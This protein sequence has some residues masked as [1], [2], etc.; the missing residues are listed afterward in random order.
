MPPLSVQP[1]DQAFRYFQQLHF[2]APASHR[3]TRRW[4]TC[5]YTILQVAEHIDHRKTCRTTYEYDFNVWCNLSIGGDLSPESG[6]RHLR[7]TRTWQMISRA[8]CSYFCRPGQYGGCW[9][10][11]GLLWFCYTYDGSPRTINLSRTIR[12]PLVNSIDSEHIP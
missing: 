4:S 6:R 3:D 12:R 7:N 10:T 2:F 9:Q 5:S 8:S 1:E 11:G